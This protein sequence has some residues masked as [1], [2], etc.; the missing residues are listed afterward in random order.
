MS[1]AW[2][3]VDALEEARRYARDRHPL[4]TGGLLLGWSEDVTGDAVVAAIVG[5]GPAAEHGLMSFLPD[6]QWQ[7]AELARRYAGSGRVHGYLGDWHTHPNGAGRASSRDRRTLASIAAAPLARAPRP[8]LAI[9][10]GDPDGPVH[11]WRHRHRFM[12]LEL[13]AT[14][15]YEP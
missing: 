14:R 2:I 1:V 6:D 3:H 5:P 13:L 7:R 8:L 11:V 4:E 10:S 15:P 12:P 9:V